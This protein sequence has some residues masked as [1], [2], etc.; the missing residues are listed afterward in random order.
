M[1]DMKTARLASTAIAALVT[2]LAIACGSESADDGSLRPGAGNGAGAGA[3]SSGGFGGSETGDGDTGE[4]SCAANVAET[5][6]G[7]A[8]IIFVIDNSGSMSEEMA[9]IRTNVNSF[10]QKIGN[11]GIDYRVIFIVRKATSPTQTGTVLCVPA[12]LAGPDCADNLPTFVHVN[13][14]VGSSNSLSLILSTY[15]TS[16]KQHLRPEATKVFVEVTD[17]ESNMSAEAFDAALL[18]KMPAGMFGTEQNR[19]YIFHS[20]ISKPANVAAPSSKMCPTGAGTSLEYQKLSTLTNGLMDEVCKAD[21]SAVLDNIAKGIVDKVGCELGYPTAEA[22][23]PSKVV[24][25]LTVNGQ[26]ARDLVQVTD[27][28]KCEQ[29]QDG[30]YYDVPSKPTKII[31]CGSTCSAANAADDAKLEALVGCKAPAPR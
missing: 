3:S 17:D 28:S 11:V 19:N 5:T 26:A 6:R 15:E 2:M 4:A 12:P 13:Q 20:I 10:A 25:R 16:W 21:Y 29:V 9:Q 7:K 23:D 27:A 1:K 24:V 8:D 18:A 30:W 31:L 14:S 22:A